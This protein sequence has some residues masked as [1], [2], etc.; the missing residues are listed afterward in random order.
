MGTSHIAA[1]YG[2]FIM[3]ELEIFNTIRVIDTATP[4]T[5]SDFNE[6]K[7]GGFLTISQS[8]KATNLCEALK[9]AYKHNLTC[10]NIVNMEDS[11]IT[12]VIDDLIKQ[13]LKD[14]S[15]SEDEQYVEKNIG[16]YQKSGLCYSDLKSFI[17]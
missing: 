14:D 12:R 1:Q 6:I 5:K 13:K 10:F 15:S 4:M 8:G 16:L 2:A 7:Y 9:L 11:D 17:P 3:R